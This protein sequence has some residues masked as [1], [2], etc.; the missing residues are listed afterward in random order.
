MKETIEYRKLVMISELDYFPRKKL[1]NLTTY[2]N[3]V[4]E[5]Q[6]HRFIR[7]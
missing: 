2:L 5:V 7:I 4:E 3:L 1:V 6:D